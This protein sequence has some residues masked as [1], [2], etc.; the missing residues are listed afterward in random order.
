MPLGKADGFGLDQFA[1]N[2]QG[3]R[4]SDGKE[5]PGRWAGDTGV[6]FKDAID[7]LDQA[8]P[9]LHALRNE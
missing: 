7:I 6:S 9:G 1:R 3:I 4:A 5:S 8:A 2:F